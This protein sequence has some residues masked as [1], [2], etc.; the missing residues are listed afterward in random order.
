MVCLYRA[1]T[2]RNRRQILWDSDEELRRLGSISSAEN[3]GRRRGGVG[4][5]RSGDTGPI[6]SWGARGK[7]WGAWVVSVSWERGRE[8]REEDSDVWAQVVIE[9]KERRSNGSG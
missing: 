3:L 6:V 4:E 2:D 9:K 1:R 5:L 8:V 7:K